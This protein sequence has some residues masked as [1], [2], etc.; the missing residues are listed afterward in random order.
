MT[1]QELIDSLKESVKGGLI[2]AEDQVVVFG[3]PDTDGAVRVDYVGI[4]TRCVSSEVTHR[5]LGYGV[6]FERVEANEKE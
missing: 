2:R 5:G 3:D 1:V 4:P 6:G